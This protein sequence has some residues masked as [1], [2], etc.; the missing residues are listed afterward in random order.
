MFDNIEFFEEPIELFADKPLFKEEGYFSLDRENIKNSLLKCD[1]SFKEIIKSIQRDV[2]Y[3]ENNFLINKEGKLYSDGYTYQYYEAITEAKKIDVKITIKAYTGT[4]GSGFSITNVKD[5][6]VEKLYLLF[7]DKYISFTNGNDISNPIRSDYFSTYELNKEYNFTFIIDDDTNFQ[8]FNYGM[9]VEFEVSE[10]IVKK[11]IYTNIDNNIALNINNF[12]NISNDSTLNI[13][14]KFNKNL[15][16]IYER[17]SY[18]QLPPKR[19]IFKD[20]DD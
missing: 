1:I 5:N 3:I 16:Y 18:I 4:Y 8:F 9:S 7:Q 19:V 17:I 2:T 12:N 10:N 15:S 14:R 6:A 13:R 20:F 11:S